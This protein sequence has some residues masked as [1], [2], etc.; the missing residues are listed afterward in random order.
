MDKK[1]VGK[2]LYEGGTMFVYEIYTPVFIV[3]RDRFGEVIKSGWE[4]CIEKIF[5]FIP[6]K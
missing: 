1:L 3:C 5:E 4:Q 6:K 2:T